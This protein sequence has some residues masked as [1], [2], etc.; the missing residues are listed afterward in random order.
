QSFH[1]NATPDRTD[2]Q[3][4]TRVT[5]LIDEELKHG[6]A[7]PPPSTG[8][9]D[10]DSDEVAPSNINERTDSPY[11]PPAVNIQVGLGVRSEVAEA[12]AIP[13]VAEPPHTSDMGGD[14]GDGVQQTDDATAPSPA[15]APAPTPVTVAAAA[16]EAALGL[17]SQSN[18]VEVGTLVSADSHT[19]L[20]DAGALDGDT[21]TDGDRT[22]EYANQIKLLPTD[23]DDDV[24]RGGATAADRPQEQTVVADTQLYAGPAVAAAAAFRARAGQAGREPDDVHNKT[25]A[26]THHESEA[27][28]EPSRATQTTDPEAQPAGTHPANHDTSHADGTQALAPS[29]DDESTE[30]VHALEAAGL[31]TTAEA[32]ANPSQPEASRLDQAQA[33]GKAYHDIAE[34]VEMAAAEVASPSRDKQAGAVHAV[35]AAGF[36]SPEESSAQPDYAA[37]APGIEQEGFAEDVTHGHN[38]VGAVPHDTAVIQPEP[39]SE[40]PQDRAHR[41]AAATADVS[42]E[43]A[44]PVLTAECAP[45]DGSTSTVVPAPAPAPESATATSQADALHAVES[46]SVEPVEAPHGVQATDLTASTDQPGKPSAGASTANGEEDLEQRWKALAFED[47]TLL[48]DLLSEDD[49]ETDAVEAAPTPERPDPLLESAEVV[50]QSTDITAA[51]AYTPVRQSP[52]QP[53]IPGQPYPPGRSPPPVRPQSQPQPAQPPTRLRS[54]LNPY[55]PQTAQPPQRNLAAPGSAATI[56]PYAPP[57]PY[58]PR[59]VASSVNLRDTYAPAAPF[60]PPPLFGPSAAASAGIPTVSPALQRRPPL[61]TQEQGQ[62]QLKTVHSF[63]DKSKGGYQ[64]PY[65]L[66]MEFTKPLSRHV[67]APPTVPQPMPRALPQGQRQPLSQTQQQSQPVRKPPATYTSVPPPPPSQRQ[68]TPKPQFAPPP[69]PSA[70]R[71]PSSASA[72]ALGT[73]A[74][75]PAAVATNAG[76][77]VPSAA[78]HTNVVS[79]A[80]AARARTPEASSVLGSTG[81]QYASP[82]ALAPRSQM[83]PSPR[84]P[85]QPIASTHGVYAGATPPAPASAPFS[86]PRRPPSEASQPQHA[87]RDEHLSLAS[88]RLRQVQGSAARHSPLSQ[89][90]TPTP[91]IHPPAP[92]PLPAFTEPDY[93]IPSDGQELDPLQRWKGAPVFK[94]GFGGTVVLTV[95]KL[96]PK[97][98]AGHI[99]PKM[100]PTPGPVQTKKLAD[101]IPHLATGEQMDTF[102]GPLVSKSKKKDVTDWMTRCIERMEAESRENED[103][104]LWKLLRLIVEHDGITS[105]TPAIVDAVCAMI[106]PS[107]TEPPAFP[108]VTTDQPPTAPDVLAKTKALSN[109]RSHLIEGSREKAVWE[110]ADNMLWGHALLLASSIEDKTTWRRVIEEFVRKELAAMPDAQSLAAL[111]QVLAGNA[112]E[113]V[114][115][116]VPPSTRAGLHMMHRS[117]AETRTAVADGLGKWRETVVLI[118]RNMSVE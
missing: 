25:S 90:R 1:D 105:W 28:L 51:Y 14:G 10:G 117:G 11:A 42:V 3:Y 114:D 101:I 46:Q 17:R 15:P 12:P 9:R 108:A 86:P 7:E 5:R 27:P 104:M 96:M 85:A 50:P 63:V 70:P 102:P 37:V 89:R 116:L 78:S 79:A 31:L 21:D 40:S 58:L 77:Y 56:S 53:Q 100:K 72:S 76:Q 6:M 112:V 23:D 43:T 55:I 52:P 35:E 69:P 73:A 87:D 57:N 91:E 115:Q 82:P 19:D 32:V 99:T 13:L 111:Y 33:Y 103:V 98:L 83:S 24:G 80:A 29:A 64:S 18:D 66:P 68:V 20:V 59:Q 8:M 36:M 67:P 62:S 93:I 74:L 38:G 22:A 61:P 95:P 60:A 97:Y 118:L 26:Y 45:N 65:D 110:A 47:S 94:S 44:V 39:D 41:S 113:C 16:Q 107:T 4:W 2:I 106:G 30:A 75:A 109:M 81:F 48:D 54:P 84:L 49:D 71:R 92:V 34:N 88:S